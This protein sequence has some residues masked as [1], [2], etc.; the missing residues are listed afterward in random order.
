MLDLRWRDKVD[1]LSA[2]SGGGRVP[3][4][5]VITGLAFSD[6]ELERLHTDSLRRVR[7]YH[8]SSPLRP[9]MPVAQLVADL[10]LSSAVVDALIASH[11]GLEMRGADV[12]V[13]S[14]RSRLDPAQESRWIEAAGQLD[15]AGL[16]VPTI[17]ELGVDADL[18]HAVA[19]SGRVVLV[20]ETFAYLP[21]QVERI[22]ALLRQ[23]EGPFTVSQA[24]DALGL[25]RKYVVPLL[26]WLD[27]RAFTKRTGDLRTVR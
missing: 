26:E 19:R 17:A 10:G 4:S 16:A 8:E 25:T 12:A 13:T 27:G 3:E 24:R 6:M 22:E 15:A 5:N 18:L 11:P 20:N 14:F 23:I 2:H 9:G 1:A 21:E 7:T